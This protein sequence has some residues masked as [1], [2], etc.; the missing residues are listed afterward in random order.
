[1]DFGFISDKSRDS[2]ASLSLGGSLGLASSRY[3]KLSTDAAIV[4]VLAV[5]FKATSLCEKGW[6]GGGGGGGRS[7]TTERFV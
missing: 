2:P 4:S 5:I 6:G 1:M 7:G 3:D